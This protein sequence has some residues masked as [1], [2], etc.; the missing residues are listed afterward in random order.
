LFRPFG[1]LAPVYVLWF[2]SSSLGPLVYLLLF[3]PFGLL[4]PV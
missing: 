2:T 3:M 4:A 1:L